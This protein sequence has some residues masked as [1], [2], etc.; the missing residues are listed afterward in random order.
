MD[1]APSSPDRQA[2]P[3]RAAAPDEVPLGNSVE[4]TLVHLAIDERGR[5]W[6]MARFEVV[7]SEP[8]VRM[9]FPPGM[10]LFDVL[11]D[12]REAHAMPVESSA[13]D[14]RLHDVRWPR[15]ILAVF[16]GEVGSL[17]DSGDAV[18]L[19]PPR[20]EGL[21]CRDMLWTID[22]PAG[23]RVRVAEPARVVDAGVWRAAQA[24]VQRRVTAVFAAA[25]EG[26]LDMDR[27]RL[28]GFAAARDAGARPALEV[29]W[30]R[31][32]QGVADPGRSRLWVVDKGL[33]GLTIRTVRPTA[34]GTGGRS[35]AT[36]VL[37]AAL[38]AGWLLAA[39]Q[40]AAWHAAVTW[41]WPWML[42]AA[43]VSW[44]V[45]LRP[46]L[47]GLALVAAGLAAVVARR[48]GADGTSATVVPASRS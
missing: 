6:G 22:A 10:R 9:R 11:V 7:A 14:V 24:E 16:A 13:W 41:S 40:P 37:V 19:E 33:E 5:I 30:E 20:L 45:V 2:L 4:A 26:T 29:E 8:L 44:V 21:P 39:W 18:L 17:V 25:V 43:G 23:M 32:I 27:E 47:P 31:A 48:Q 3:P 15:S 28:R 1:G 36:A 46:M 34:P 35:A 38:V 42:A 12:G